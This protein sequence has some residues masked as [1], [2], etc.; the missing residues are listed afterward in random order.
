VD[1]PLLELV[2]RLLGDPPR[3]PA[4]GLARLLELP[5][6]RHEL[7]ARFAWAIPNEAALADLAD[8]GPL[9]EAGAGTGYW[10]AL[11]QAR[12]AD[13]VA[14]DVAPPGGARPNPH[15][16]GRHTWTRVETA[17]AVTAVHAHPD[18]TLFLCWPP[19]DDEAGY[20]AVRAYSGDVFAYVGDGLGPT[21]RATG[22]PRLHRELALNWT[23]E[24]VTA[25]PT[26]P[27]VAD[28]L[29]VFRRNPVRRPHTTRTRCDECRRYVPTDSIGRCARCR[30]RHPA[31]LTLQLG[32]HRLEYPADVLEAMHPA[33]ATALRHSAHRV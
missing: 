26:W 33:L 17:D 20:R 18:R 16:P 29:V 3:P 22:T 31:E 30:E 14:Y 7:A 5:A 4:P 27:G 13:L 24:S 23:P 21:A 32:A 12:G 8:L 6:H 19:F 28:R 9:V 15:H 11:L 25:L 2:T 1:N 10:A